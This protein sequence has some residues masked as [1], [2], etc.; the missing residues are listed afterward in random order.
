MMKYMMRIAIAA[1]ALAGAVAP[2]L[3]FE[4][5]ASGLS[6]QQ[7][8]EGAQRV[9]ESFARSAVHVNTIV[10]VGCG[11]FVLSARR[12]RWSRSSPHEDSGRHDD[13]D[14]GVVMDEA[15]P[16]AAKG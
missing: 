3:A 6:S 10:S 14:S 11:C 12:Q 16:D 8:R 5:L 2:A 13:G 1:V 7:P 15:T 4:K 9:I